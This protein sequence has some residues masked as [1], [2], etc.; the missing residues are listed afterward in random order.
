M[1]LP[2]EQVELIRNRW[3]RT[4]KALHL[5]DP[6]AEDFGTGGLVAL[7]PEVC[8]RLLVL[9]GDPEGI[10]LP[11][12]D[13]TFWEW[14]C[15]ERPNPFQGTRPTDWGSQRKPTVDAAVRYRPHDSE[16]WRWDTYL[17]LHRNGAMEFGL[18]EEGSARWAHR[19]GEGERRAFFLVS[20]V[21]RVWVAIALYGEVLTQYEIQGPWEVSLALRQTRD[22]LLGNVAAGWKDFQDW[23][24]RDAPT[25]PHP[26]LLVRREVGAW[27]TGDGARDLAFALGAT[28][29]DAWGITDRRFL[30]R[31]DQP[32]GGE[33]DVSRYGG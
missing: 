21:G 2:V 20:I 1:N 32:G 19:A 30:I 26:N 24:P 31:P 3:R 5:T 18:G 27:P 15:R 12:F 7:A 28:V 11:E 9:P 33:F 17:A 10:P 14:W 22:A 16:P 4:R 13:T 25:C 29:E 8:V 6:S 23:F